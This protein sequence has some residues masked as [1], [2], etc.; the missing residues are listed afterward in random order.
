MSK[1]EL[2]AVTGSNNTSR[3]NDNFQKIED[4]LNQEVLYRKG[5]VGEPNE[6]ETD[7][8]MNGKRILNLPDATTLTEPVTLKQLG[9]V[10][11]GVDSALRTELA[12]SEGGGLVGTSSGKTVQESFDSS[13]LVYGNTS[14]SYKISGCAIRRDTTISADWQLVSDSAHIPINVSGVTNGV[15]VNIQYAGSKIGTLVAGPDERFASDGVLVGASVGANNA[16]ISLGAPCQFYVDFD[17]SNNI[18]YD[19]KFFDISRFSVSVAGSGLIT[20]S[21]PQRRLMQMPMCLHTTGG[22]FF[23]H[24]VPH[25]VNPASTGTTSL[26]LVGESEGLI[27]YNGTSW[28]L[29]SSSWATADLTFSFD[30]PTGVLTVTHPQ[31]LGSPGV[32]V[33]PYDNGGDVTCHVSVVTGTGFKVKFRK[34]DGTV[35]SLSSALGFYFSRGLSSIRK[36]PTGR[37]SV[38]LG[39]VQ[40]N[41]NHVDYPN[42]N[43]WFLS[44]MQG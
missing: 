10:E 32:T 20:L 1:I 37:L 13:G 16:N 14:V 5:Y 11:S 4:A 9:E 21:H 6:M 40:V 3:I 26:Y 31:V 44:A 33:T 42:G 25:Y 17:D 35:P 8:D 12:S 28:T 30:A 23:E 27:S 18:V 39:H 15:D 7:L 41:C 2:P 24:L 22:S 29:G 38:F 34:L 36:V 19:S 43:F